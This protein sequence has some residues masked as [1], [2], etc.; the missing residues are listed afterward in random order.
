MATIFYMRERSKPG[1]IS[2]SREVS[3]ADLISLYGSDPAKYQFM[4][5]ADS[6]DIT[7]DQG[8]ASAGPGPARIIVKIESHE[9]TKDTFPEEGF[10]RVRDLIP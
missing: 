3:V 8:P 6:P 9:V 4:Q 1:N 7:T 10:Y 5:G 2:S